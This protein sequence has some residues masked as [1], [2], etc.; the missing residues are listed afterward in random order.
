MAAL[1]RTVGKV[2]FEK[3]VDYLQLQA[4][5]LYRE[6]LHHAVGHLVV[7]AGSSL[8]VII[9]RLEFPWWKK[10]TEAS[11]ITEW[12]AI[13]SARAFISGFICFTNGWPT[14][15]FLIQ[16]TSVYLVTYLNDLKLSKVFNVIW[17]DDLCC[18]GFVNLYWYYSQCW[19]VELGMPFFLTHAQTL[20][21]TPTLT[22][23]EPFSLLDFSKG[24]VSFRQGGYWTSL[25]A[26]ERFYCFPDVCRLRSHAQCVWKVFHADCVANCT[27]LSTSL[28]LSFQFLSLKVLS[29]SFFSSIW[30]LD[31]RIE[32]A[33]LGKQY[34]E[35]LKKSIPIKLLAF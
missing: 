32:A 15:L 9:T 13:A 19:L 14:F 7:S 27:V 33:S 24:A 22:L 26:S 6:I 21:L 4:F 35:Y 3:L 25:I 17:Q 5:G 18:V 1:V 2:L 34:F 23:V 31:W 30:N 11:F 8:E 12:C 20:F 16:A 10:P 29:K 28:W